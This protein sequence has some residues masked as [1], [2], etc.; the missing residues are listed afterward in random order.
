M[1]KYVALLLALILVLSMTACGLKDDGIRPEFKENMD[2]IEQFVDDYVAFIDTYK[3]TNDP[4]SMMTEYST[5]LMQHV[6]MM[7]ELNAI[8]TTDLSEEE[9]AYYEEVVARINQKLKG[10]N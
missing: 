9:L 6:Q 7:D 10:I 8:D 4:I 2:T 5:M 3:N 1:K